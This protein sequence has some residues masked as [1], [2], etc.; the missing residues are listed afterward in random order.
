MKKS[1][2]RKALFLQ[3]FL[4]FVKKILKKCKKDVDKK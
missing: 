2:R 3:G 4:Y 1:F